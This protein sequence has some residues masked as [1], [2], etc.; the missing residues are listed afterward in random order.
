MPVLSTWA[1]G[2]PCQFDAAAVED[3]YRVLQDADLWDHACAAAIYVQSLRLM[4][5][6]MHDTKVKSVRKVDAIK[7]IARIRRDLDA[8]QADID[9]I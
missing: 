1:A 8:K 9:R 4:A 3:H 2:A 7:Q 6:V 5:D